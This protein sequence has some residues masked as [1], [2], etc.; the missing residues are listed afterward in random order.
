MDTPAYRN[1]NL[2]MQTTSQRKYDIYFLQTFGK[3]M[4]DLDQ[5]PYLDNS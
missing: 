4:E 1:K 3:C 2:F 5:T